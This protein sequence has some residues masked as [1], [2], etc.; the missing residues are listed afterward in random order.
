MGGWGLRGHR[1]RSLN[2]L[3]HCMHMQLQGWIFPVHMTY[4][5]CAYLFPLFI[6]L[7]PL[8]TSP[9]HLLS[10][11]HR[12]THTDIPLFI[13]EKSPEPGVPRM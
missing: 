12:H 4:F 3:V 5:G 13:G 2:F 6:I 11:P 10:L 8:R 7:F 1:S 9:A